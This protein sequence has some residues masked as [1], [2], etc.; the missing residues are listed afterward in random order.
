MKGLSDDD[1]LSLAAGTALRKDDRR[2]FRLGAVGIRNDGTI[3][4]A[5]NGPSPYPCAQVHAE[6]RLSQ[7]LTPGSTVWVARI[8]H[9]G[10]LGMARPC[11]TCERRLK[12]AGVHR[13]VY[14]ISD[15]EHGVIDLT[16]N[17]ERIRP[18]RGARKHRSKA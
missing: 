14:T 17:A 18:S 10:T 8:R 4:S 13:V 9:D 1:M 3:V 16:R 2:S 6:V 12:S 7:K 11:P 5:A 15:A